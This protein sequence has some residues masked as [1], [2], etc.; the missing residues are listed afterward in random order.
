[1]SSCL[2]RREERDWLGV[3]TQD[4]MPRIIEHWCY[5]CTW[6]ATSRRFA[7]RF[8]AFTLNP[9]LRLLAAVQRALP[10]LP[11]RPL[12]QERLGE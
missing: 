10:E 11:R 1:M 9:A 12:R 8:H 3:R 4:Q 5:I 7:P 2:A 6:E